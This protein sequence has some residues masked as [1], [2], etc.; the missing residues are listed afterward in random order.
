MSTTAKKAAQIIAAVMAAAL[1]FFGVKDA[2]STNESAS[3]RN[4]VN[5]IAPANAGGGWDSVA[6]EIQ[7]VMREENIVT[8]PTVLNI[9]GAGGTI[10]L[11]Q[12]N[13]MSGDATTLMITGAVMLGAIHVNSSGVDLGDVTPIAR[14]AD[15]YNVLAVSADAPYDSVD[16]LVAE[17][18]KDPRDFPWGGGSTGSVDQMIIAQLASEAGLDPADANYMAHSGGAE[19]ATALMAGTI[20][21]SVSGYN[22]FA[23]QIEAG[24]L[25]VLA[26]SAKKPV[27]GIDAPTLLE[28]GYNV[29]M[30]NWRGVVAPPGLSDEEVEELRAIMKEVLETESWKNVLQRNRWEDSA[31]VG[32]PFAENLDEESE[33]VDGIWTDLGY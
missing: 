16:E 21:A 26:V 20:K 9:P 23:D 17:W 8:N 1:V 31:L 15:D 27:E 5:I 3:A 18:K 11:S 2:A 28:E 22:D 14:I 6:R 4:A 7:Q 24:R 13:E 10:G 32:E 30:V 19:L 25:K 12:L 33:L 29:D